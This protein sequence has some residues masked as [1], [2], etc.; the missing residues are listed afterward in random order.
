MVK[1]NYK[2]SKRGSR[3]RAKLKA[4]TK[5]PL[6]DQFKIVHAQS[7]VVSLRDLSLLREMLKDSTAIFLKTA[8]EHCRVRKCFIT[9]DSRIIINDNLNRNF[10]DPHVIGSVSCVID[11]INGVRNHIITINQGCP[12]CN[13]S[14]KRIALKHIQKDIAL[15]VVTFVDRTIERLGSHHWR[16]TTPKEIEKMKGTRIA[17]IAL[18]AFLSNYYLGSLPKTMD[19][20]VYRTALNYDARL[21]S[22]YTIEGNYVTVKNKRMPYSSISQEAAAFIFTVSFLP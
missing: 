15:F 11:Y 5:T 2:K 22:F 21:S 9:D 13:S 20:G 12:S 8:I 18:T 17:I 4:F 7:G 6:E 3:V 19:I 10:S 14:R 1:K 16:N